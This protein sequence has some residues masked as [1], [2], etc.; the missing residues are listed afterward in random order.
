MMA[1][2]VPRLVY[3]YDKSYFVL[4]RPPNKVLHIVPL[5]YIDDRNTIDPIQGQYVEYRE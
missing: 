4:Y 1:P 3:C 2:A 5:K